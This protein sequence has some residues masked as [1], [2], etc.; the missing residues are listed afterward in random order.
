MSNKEKAENFG[1][2]TYDNILY[3]ILS[4]NLLS[5]EYDVNAHHYYTNL[6]KNLFY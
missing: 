3:N 2:L 6:F 4:F 1:L 5:Y